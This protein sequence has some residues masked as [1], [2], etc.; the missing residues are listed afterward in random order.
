MHFQKLF[1]EDTVKRKGEMG[2][3]IKTFDPLLDKRVTTDELKN[4]FNKMKTGKAA[5]PDQILTE[6]LKSFRHV[7]EDTLL[8]IINAIFSNHI[9]PSIWT[10]KNLKPIYKKLDA[11]LASNYR[12]LAIGSAFAKLFSFILL[13]RLN[14]FIESKKLITPNQIGFM[15]G[16]KTSDHVF[17]LKTIIEKIVKNKGKTLYAAF[18]DF[19]K[20]YDTV[21]RNVLIDRLKDLGING[22]LLQNVEAMYQKTEYLV[23]YNNGH[24]DPISCKVGLK[25]GCPLS[26]MLFNLYIDDI[27]NIFDNTCDPIDFQGK[28]I[29]HFLYADDLVILSSSEKG[30]QI[31]LDKLY[32][33]A[34]K[35]HL[36]VSIDKSKTIIFNKTGKLIRRFFN[37]G[38]EIL[39]PVRTFCYL[40]YEINA[41]GTN[42]TAINYLCD[43]ASKAMQTIFR[44]AARFNIPAKTSIRLFDAY[45][46]PIILYNVENWGEMTNKGLQNFTKEHFWKDIINAKASNIHR[47]YLKFILGVTKSCPNLAVMGETGEIPLALKGYRLMLQYWYRVTNLS[48]DNLAK[49]ALLENINL[50]TNW[51]ITIEKLINTFNLSDSIQSTNKLRYDAKKSIHAAFVEHWKNNMRAHNGRLE[52]YSKYKHTFE[53]EEYLQIPCFDKRKAITKL[54]CSDHELEIERGRH[55]KIPREARLCKVCAM[56]DIETEEHFLFECSYYEDI[57]NNINFTN[58]IGDLSA[59]ANSGEFILLALAKR[60]KQIELGL[61]K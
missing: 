27:A 47:K 13:N 8:K 1:S 40:G 4:A 43:K 56:G 46:S 51:I 9:Y 48:N 6:Y 59:I 58:A 19:K 20:A 31:S 10:K 3:Y 55:N 38:G 54:R 28:E 2:D 42:N 15:K 36:A 32:D 29:S 16:S 14:N 5:G 45:V 21:D 11:K 25:Q 33:F 60:R 37:I 52:F 49:K 18:I 22:I 23:K 17:I 61:S 26:P 57:R 39:E 30:L 44:T 34:K 24:L 50:K 35:K 41:G 7:A 12:G 53:F